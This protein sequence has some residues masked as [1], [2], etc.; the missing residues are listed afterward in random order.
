KLT[1][2]EAG[3]PPAPLAGRFPSY[4]DMFQAMVARHEAGFGHEVVK[5]LD[6]AALPA[7]EGLDAVLI[8]GSPAGAYEDHLWLPPLRQ[9]NRAAHDAGTRMVGV[10]FGH[11]IIADALGGVVR[12]SEKGWGLGRHDYEVVPFPPY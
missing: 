6:G 10:C 2:I 9:F 4:P 5:I 12:K 7:P 11:Q 8:T 1:I 3:A